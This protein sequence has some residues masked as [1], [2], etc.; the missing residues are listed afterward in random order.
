MEVTGN[1]HVPVQSSDDGDSDSTLVQVS[2]IYS[3]HGRFLF[4]F[5]KQSTS[6]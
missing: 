4:K 2:Q 1:N 3:C 5:R 6:F